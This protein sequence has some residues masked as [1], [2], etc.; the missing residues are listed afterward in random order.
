MLLTFICVAAARL[1]PA[2]RP[3]GGSLAS[4]PF[5]CC[6]FYPLFLICWRTSHLDLALHLIWTRRSLL[7]SPKGQNNLF[8]IHGN[9]SWGPTG[10]ADHPTAL[11]SWSCSTMIPMDFE[12]IVSPLWWAQQ[13]PPC[14]DQ[15]KH[16]IQMRYPPADKE[17]NLEKNVI[18]HFY[19]IL[20]V[21]EVPYQ[22]T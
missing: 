18:A 15:M 12:Q 5:S 13:A 1:P 6:Y 16:K 22:P 10:F 19:K 14:S 9:H 17:S 4:S 20:L 8:K 2:C 21:C 7:C 11:C 3:E